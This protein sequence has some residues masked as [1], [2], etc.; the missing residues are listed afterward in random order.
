MSS[1]NQQMP[2]T[3]FALACEFGGQVEVRPVRK[4]SGNREFLGL[5][6]SL[7]MMNTDGVSCITP[8]TKVHGLDRLNLES[9]VKERTQPAL[10]YHFN[11][12]VYCCSVLLG[13]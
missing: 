1:N 4:I 3:I 6:G 10:M 11:F 13:E 5:I 2:V 9:C 8:H 12:I 7:S